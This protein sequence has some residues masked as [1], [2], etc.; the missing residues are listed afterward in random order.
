MLSLLHS[1]GMTHALPLTWDVFPVFKRCRCAGA[2]G[3][4]RGAG[5]GERRRWRSP[6][7]LRPAGLL[8]LVLGLQTGPQQQPPAACRGARGSG[9][10]EASV[11]VAMVGTVWVWSGHSLCPREFGASRCCS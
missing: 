8:G 5:R 9:G 6:G 1:R 11:W 7:G 2:V 10:G 3:E 4:R